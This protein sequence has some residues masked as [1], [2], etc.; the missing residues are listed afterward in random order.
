MRGGDKDRRYVLFPGHSDHHRFLKGKMLKEIT[1]GLREKRAGRERIG[2]RIPLLKS[3][4]TRRELPRIAL[5]V[6]S[7]FVLGE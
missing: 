7:L 2:Y 5:F 4:V 1:C 6:L 3:E